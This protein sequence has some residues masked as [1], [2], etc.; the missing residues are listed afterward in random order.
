VIQVEGNKGRS[1]QAVFTV[2]GGPSFQLFPSSGGVG[3]QVTIKG[4][5]FLPGDNP[6]SL[7]SPTDSSV[8]L[9][10]A[11]NFFTVTSGKFNVFQNVTGSFIV[12]SAPPGGYAIQ[13]DGS[14]GDSAQAIFTVRSQFSPSIKLKCSNPACTV[15]LVSGSGFNP[16]DYCNSGSFSSTPDG[17]ISSASCSMV[18]GKIIAASFTV[19]KGVKHGKYM[20]ILIA[21]T[22]DSARATFTVT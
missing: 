12:G 3:I 9:N 17:L 21:S 22:L 20:V 7:S 15:V 16:A 19:A 2:T 1:V 13:V 5:G 4:T 11:C 18:N 14:L 6:C 10:G 8:V